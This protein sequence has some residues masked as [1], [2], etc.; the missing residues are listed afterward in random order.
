MSAAAARRVVFV[1]ITFHP[2]PGALRGLPLAT[3][4]RDR[5][6]WDVEVITAVPWY[7]LGAPYPGYALHPYQLEVVDG[8]PVHRFWIHPSHD[9]SAARRIVTYLSFMCST[10][11]LAAF[12]VRRAPVIYHVDNQPTTGITVAWL[13][14]LWGARVVQHIGDLW[15]DTVM[16]SGM[17]GRG[18]LLGW[19]E[20]ALH[21]LMRGIY[22]T[23][24]TITVITEGFRRTLVER[25]VPS[26]KVRIL[27]NW[28]EEDRL[29]PVAPSP[30]LR[31]ELDLEGRFVVLYAGN[32]GPLQSLE[33]TLDA[34]EQ[35]R[36][37]PEVCFV[38]IG[39]GPSRPA[40][41][42]EVARRNL[43]AQVRLLPPRPVSDMPALN[44]LCDALL[45]HLKD[46]PF[47]HETVPSKTQVS[48]YAGRPI[49]M[50]ARGEAA[51]IVRDAAAGF[52]FSPEHGDEL[53]AAVRALADLDPLERAAMGQRGQAYY[54]AHLSLENGAQVMHEIFSELFALPSDAVPAEPAAL[55]RKVVVTGLES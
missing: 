37:R 54:A 21:L 39:S 46:E 31:R 22:A 30:S 23:N 38:L 28:A 24:D 7:P 55:D 29:R 13:R 26:S 51:R 44:A 4:L 2:E 16:A 47:L 3:A 42:A 25:G 19:L 34:A 52:V 35:L 17:V 49:L 20:G 11:A 41:E 27:P 5:F 12:R 40:L 1:T 32:M 33:V 48:L 53:A 45:V 18:P 8:I 36:D 43:G 50:G 14:L 6:G 10:L 15:P 9:R